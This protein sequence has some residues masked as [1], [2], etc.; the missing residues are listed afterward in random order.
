MFLIRVALPDRP[1]SLG[2]VAAAMGEVGADI[3]AVEIVGRLEDGRVVDDFMFTLPDGVMPDNAVS[4]CTQVDGVNVMWCARYPGGGSLDLDIEVLERMLAEPENA[5]EI[6]CQS[7]PSVFHCHWAVLLNKKERRTL[8]ATPLAPDLSPEEIDAIGPFDFTRTAELEKGWVPEWPETILVATP[9]RGGR[10]L[11]LGRN[12]GPTFL[13]SE[14]ARL[15]HLAA[16][17]PVG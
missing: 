5:A 17:V 11:L 1:G 10:A 2:G 7:A 3:R 8:H 15:R 13:A 9:V 12:G 16:L 14:V 6:L 4:A